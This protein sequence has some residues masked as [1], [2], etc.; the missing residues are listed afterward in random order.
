MFVLIVQPPLWGLYLFFHLGPDGEG[1]DDDLDGVALAEFRDGKTGDAKA[2]RY[3]FDLAC[4]DG[5]GR[6]DGFFVDRVGIGAADFCVYMHLQRVALEDFLQPAQATAGGGVLYGADGGFGL[7]AT[8][9]IRACTEFDDIAFF[10][11]ATLFRAALCPSEGRPVWFLPVR[12]RG[13]YARL[14]AGE[15]GLSYD[16][17]DRLFWGIPKG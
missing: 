11:R 13:R 5:N 6:K 12:R 17:R 1:G 2:A 3:D 7:I 16:R 4:A 9:Q 15:R 10:H 14:S 8:V